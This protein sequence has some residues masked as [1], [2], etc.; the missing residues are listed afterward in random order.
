MKK[1]AFSSSNYIYYRKVTKIYYNYLVSWL[2]LLLGSSINCLVVVVV[3][4]NVV[5]LMFDGRSERSVDALLKPHN[6]IN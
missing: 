4:V 1:I 6:P 5:A 2:L 3:N